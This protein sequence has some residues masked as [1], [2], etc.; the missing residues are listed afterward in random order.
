MNIIISKVGKRNSENK[1]VKKVSQEI[2]KKK[3]GD[4]KK[5]AKR[6]MR[7]NDVV[8]IFENYETISEV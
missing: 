8:D 2:D 6:E 1:S 3:K 7:M 4:E 5:S